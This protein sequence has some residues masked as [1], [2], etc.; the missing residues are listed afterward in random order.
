MI[1][2]RDDEG[3]SIDASLVGELLDVSPADVQALMR[4][5]QI[6]SLCERGEGEHAG[7]YRLTFFYEG[8]RA[9]LSV[10]DFGRI[11]RRSVID[12]GKHPLPPAL[13]QAGKHDA[14]KRTR[15]DRDASR[16]RAAGDDPDD[17]SASGS[18][19]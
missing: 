5:G 18:M 15:T 13:H 12:Y 6:T 10:D 17:A 1:L 8:R 4:R 7:Q 2:E 19:P 11:V 16:K 14:D 3:F 9:R